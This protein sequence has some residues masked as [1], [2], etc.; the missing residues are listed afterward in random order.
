MA[1]I[2]HVDPDMPANRMVRIFNQQV[3]DEGTLTDALAKSVHVT[4]SQKRNQRR[5]E[6]EYKK[7]RGYFKNE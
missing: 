5:R 6:I 2:V 4:D 3:S 7:R 1:T